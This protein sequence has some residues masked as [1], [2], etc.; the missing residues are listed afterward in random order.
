MLIENMTPQDSIALLERTGLGRLAC[1]HEG[2]PY[3]T[4]I[5]FA[6]DADY[7][8]SFSTLGQKIVWMRANPL[9]CLQA[10]EVISRQQWT[11][12]VVSGRYEE[13]SSSSEHAD[14]R[15]RAHQLLKKRAAWW[16][17]AYVKTLL[18]GKERPLETLYFRIRIHQISGHKAT[19]DRNAQEP[20]K[21]WLRRMLGT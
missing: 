17:P 16:E 3:I 8:Y 18:D 1:S 4:P 14:A 13:L 6:H 11:S 9:V 19:P 5:T 15:E 12:V 7:L 10:D 2:Q 21:T 20:S